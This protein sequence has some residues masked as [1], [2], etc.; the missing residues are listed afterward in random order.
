MSICPSFSFDSYG[1]RNTF[2]TKPNAENISVREKLYDD[3]N[4]KLIRPERRC[5]RSKTIRSAYN[6]CAKQSL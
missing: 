2:T 5:N 6:E 1:S 3:S 4:A